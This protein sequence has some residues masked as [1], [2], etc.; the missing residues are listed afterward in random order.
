MEILLLQFIHS[1]LHALK[2]DLSVHLDSK[3]RKKGDECQE[4]NDDYLGLII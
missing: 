4:G 1:L 3:S 2:Y